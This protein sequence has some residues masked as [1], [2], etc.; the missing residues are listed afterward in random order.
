MAYQYYSTQV[1]TVPI[2]STTPGTT[3]YM[4]PQAQC[5]HHS[6]PQNFVQVQPSLQVQL[7]DVTP[8]VTENPV[9]QQVTRLVPN[10]LYEDGNRSRSVRNPRGPSANF[11]DS[12]RPYHYSGDQ[13]SYKRE[14]TQSKRGQSNSRN[15]NRYNSNLA[16]TSKFGSSNYLSTPANPM[17]TTRSIFSSEHYE[18]L[19]AS[20]REFNAKRIQ[21]QKRDRKWLSGNDL[22]RKLDS[23]APKSPAN[24]F[25]S[26]QKLKSIVTVVNTPN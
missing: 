11:C 25:K 14:S 12:V 4:Q 16:K 13:V 15:R 21:R 10:H 19:P 1:P 18:P 23:R 26:S 5:L 6:V 7:Q 8:H 2:P 20:L 24:K 3:F 22:R 9:F 17:A